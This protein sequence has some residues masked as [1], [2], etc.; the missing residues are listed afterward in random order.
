MAI[1][2]PD[3]LPPQDAGTSCHVHLSFPAREPGRKR[4]DGKAIFASRRAAGQYSTPDLKPDVA[5][6]HAISISSPRHLHILR[7]GW[8]ALPH[9]VPGSPCHL[10]DEISSDAE[11]GDL[12][13]A[14]QSGFACWRAKIFSDLLN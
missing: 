7:P 1:P 6:P 9:K 13:V 14:V 12:D 4:H 2:F 3:A 11:P 10:E 8:L 5:F